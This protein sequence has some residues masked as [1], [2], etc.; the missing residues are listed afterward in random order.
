MKDEGNIVIRKVS[1]ESIPIIQKITY[2]TWPDAYKNILSAKQLMYMLELIYSTSSLQRQINQEHQ[3]FIIASESGADIGFAAFSAIS[4]SVFKLHKIY[5]LPNQQGKGLGKLLINYIIEEIKKLHA[6][7]LQLNVNRHNKAK[8]FY[9]HLGF[10][11]IAEEDIDIGN[12]YFMND[13]IME[14]KLQ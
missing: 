2:E 1:T 14:K 8:S 12:G 4:K 11:V 10:S 9:E 7:S 5:T 6:T 13:F 3:Q